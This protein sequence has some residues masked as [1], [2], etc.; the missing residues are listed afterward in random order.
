MRD[1]SAGVSAGTVGIEGRREK[2]V[3][4]SDHVFARAYMELQQQRQVEHIDVSA[5]TAASQAQPEGV[6]LA[7]LG[8]GMSTADIDAKAQQVVIRRSGRVVERLADEKAASAFADKTGLSAEDRDTLLKLAALRAADGPAREAAKAS[9]G[10]DARA[11]DNMVNTLSQ[12]AERGR[13]RA[14]VQ[15]NDAQVYEWIERQ[16]QLRAQQEPAADQAGPAARAVEGSQ[17]IERQGALAAPDQARA[18]P[19]EVGSQFTKDGDQYDH[20]QSKAVAFVD[21]GD[22]LSTS[23]STPKMA[24]ALVKVAEG[25][26]GRPVHGRA[27]VGQG[28]VT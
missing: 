2:S 18:M 1:G 12:A 24:E 15:Q 8:K 9:I 19:P 3:G 25:P 26:G 23:A 16:R 10:K 6:R 27:G 28:P 13:A 22:K 14:E 5:K 4:S 21:R 17:T 11:T 20:Q 7:S